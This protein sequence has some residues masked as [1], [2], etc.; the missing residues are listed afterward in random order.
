MASVHIQL[1]LAGRTCSKQ[2]MMHM[3]ELS[4]LNSDKAKENCLANLVQAKH[5]FLV[6]AWVP[7]GQDGIHSRPDIDKRQVECGLESVPSSQTQCKAGGRWM[8]AAAA[9]IA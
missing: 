9:W 2:V 6:Y 1:S 5:P 4:R 7:L 8:C 3:I